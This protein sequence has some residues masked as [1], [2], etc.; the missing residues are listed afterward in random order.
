MVTMFSR[1]DL[2]RRVHLRHLYSPCGYH[3]QDQD[4]TRK[5]FKEC[6]WNS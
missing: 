6:E 4:T 1:I 5:E 2:S 3:W